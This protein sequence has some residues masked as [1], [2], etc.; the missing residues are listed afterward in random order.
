M[1]V[2]LSV[3]MGLVLLFPAVGAAKVPQEKIDH[4]TDKYDRLFKKYSKHYFGPNFDWRWFKSQGIAESGLDP[5]ARSKSGAKG[6]MQIMPA[7]YQE[8]QDKNPHFTDI[9]SPR[10]NIAAGIYYNHMLYKKWRTPP[11]GNERLYFTF[12]SYNAGYSRVYQALKR[13]TPP[14]GQWQEVSRYLPAQTRHYVR[15]IQRLMGVEKQAVRQQTGMGRQKT[16]QLWYMTDKYLPRRNRVHKQHML[17]P[18]SRQM[19]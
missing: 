14:S 18:V 19:A 17:Q 10:W 8:I 2:I 1:P 3:M 6:I 5:H 7:T 13:L 16:V 15:R 4:W 12:G 11:P 9:T